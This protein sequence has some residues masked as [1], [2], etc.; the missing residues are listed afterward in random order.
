MPTT[1]EVLETIRQLEA[2][3]EQHFAEKEREWKY[4]VERGRVR[5]EKTVVGQHREL[6]TRLDRYLRDSPLLTILS[7]PLI[8]SLAVPLVLLDL[9]VTIFQSICFPIYGIAK[10]RRRDYIALDRGRLAYLNGI[11]RVNCDFCGYANGVIAYVREVA[12][13]TEQYWCPIRHSRAVR[14]P[15]AH[16]PLFTDYGDARGYHLKLADLRR[17]LQDGREGKSTSAR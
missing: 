6:R 4:R 3:L 5:F 2:D 13:R 1:T 15:H 11:E 16:Y 7:S 9:W 8:Y 10:V 17:S 14:G 12:G